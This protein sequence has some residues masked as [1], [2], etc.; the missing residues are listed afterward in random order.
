MIVF[1]WNLFP[2]Y[3]A[4]CIGAFARTTDEPVAV[5]ATRPDVPIEGMER[6]CGCPVYW[7]ERGRDGGEKRWRWTKEI[8]TLFTTG[9][10]VPAFNQLRD[11][12]RKQGGRTVCLVDNNFIPS[13]REI[14]KSIRFRLLIRHHYDGFIVPGKSGRKLLRFYGVPDEKIAEGFYAADESLFRPGPALDERP[15]RIIYVGRFCE[16]KNVRR[17]LEA[18][19][20]WRNEVDSGWELHLYGSGP[21]KDELVALVRAG[22]GDRDGTVEIH[23]FLQ[24]EELAAKYR[25]ARILCL[26]SIEEH[27]GLVVQEAVLS[28]CALLV[29]DRV[30]AKEDFLEEGVNGLSF[31]PYSVK[32]M[33]E[34]FAEAMTRKFE[35]ESAAERAREMGV[36]RFVKAVWQKAMEGS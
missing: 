4:R 21:L 19:A 2:Q 1:A 3:A 23:D 5:V 28:G 36:K 15:K 20:R 31:N 35:T 10:D 26:P 11:L 22:C 32:D 9:W 25:E 24:P 12:V 8:T 14:V 34:K 13:L 7:V 33:A 30:G 6:L 29:S 17:M 18:F 16:R 27:W